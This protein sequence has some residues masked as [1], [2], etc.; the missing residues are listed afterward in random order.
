VSPKLLYT[1]FRRS[2]IRQ[3]GCISILAQAYFDPNMEL[4]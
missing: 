4:D 1:M 3:S 2:S